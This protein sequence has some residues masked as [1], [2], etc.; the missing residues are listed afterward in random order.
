MGSTGGLI[1]GITARDV[2]CATANAVAQGW[3]AQAGAA[4][5]AES[6][7]FDCVVVAHSGDNQTV[8][9]TN[10]GQ[11]VNLVLFDTAEQ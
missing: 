10:D 4:T 7:G 5:Q 11:Q 2:S 3:A 8:S 1:G 9:C 6:H